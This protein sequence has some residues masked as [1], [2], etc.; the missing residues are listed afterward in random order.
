MLFD[1]QINDRAKNIQYRKILYKKKYSIGRSIKNDLVILDKKIPLFWKTIQ[2]LDLKYTIK[3]CSKLP[4]DTSGK[5]FVSVEYSRFFYI[6]CVFFSA[7]IAYSLY[8]INFKDRLQ[9][10]P[11]QHAVFLPLK[12]AQGVFDDKSQAKTKLKFYFNQNPLSVQTNTYLHFSVGNIEESDLLAVFVNDQLI[13][14]AQNSGRASWGKEQKL[15]IPQ[16]IL[17]TKKNSLYFKLQRERSE[18]KKWGVK[19]VYIDHAPAKTE[20]DLDVLAIKEY[21]E[22][23]LTLPKPDAKD[24]QRVAMIQKKYNVLKVKKNIM[25]SLSSN[26]DRMFKKIKAQENQYFKI[27]ALEEKRYGQLIKYADAEITEYP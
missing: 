25:L 11:K 22:D 13:G 26:L 14:Y 18:E 10:I 7:S 23:F 1:L 6:F 5:F 9:Q 12:S 24:Y 3:D 16:T 8:R 17:K 4:Q 21:L 15:T 2:R 19:N 27:K 20:Y